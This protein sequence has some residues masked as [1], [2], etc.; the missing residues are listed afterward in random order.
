MTND[1]TKVKP[2]FVIGSPRSGT[3]ILAMGLRASLG[4]QSYSEGHF[5]PLANHLLDALKNYYVKMTDSLSNERRAIAHIDRGAFEERILDLF[6]HEYNSLY[7]GTV[8]LDKTPGFEMIRAVPV[9]HRIWPDAKFIFAKRRGIEN[10]ISRL[11]KFP[12]VSFEKHC[13]TWMH[14]MEKWLE[15]RDFVSGFAVEV[16]QREIL[17][18]PQSAA[19]GIG[20]FLDL[21]RPAVDL[22]HDAFR[23][24]YPEST[25]GKTNHDAT[26]LNQAGWS[27][28]QIEIFRTSCGVTNRKFGYSETSSYYL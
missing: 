2:V 27:D 13:S 24:E 26:D 1:R 22:L 17:I 5:L 28:Q 14:C 6:Y 21:E 7:S 19:E 8:W 23:N 9:L 3:S 4:I 25:S 10:I 11:K 20:G 16:E 12:E 15:V 18:N